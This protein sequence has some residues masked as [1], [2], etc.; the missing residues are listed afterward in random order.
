MI[1]AVIVL[2]NCLSTLPGLLENQKLLLPLHLLMEKLLLTNCHGVSKKC[3]PTILT[4]LKLDYLIDTGIVNEVA[5][6]QRKNVKSSLKSHKLRNAS[7][8][9]NLTNM[10]IVIAIL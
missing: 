7:C 9:L 5:D 6:L 2:M 8:L 3:S 1:T 4:Q 10:S